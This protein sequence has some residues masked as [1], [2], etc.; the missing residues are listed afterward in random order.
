LTT[1]QDVLYGALRQI[2]SVTPGEPIDGTEASN[3]LTVI[4]RLLAAFSMEWG[5]IQDVTVENFPL[6]VGQ[7]SYTW[8]IGGNFNSVRPDKIFNC[9]IYDSQAGIR[10]PL[11]VLSDNQYQGIMLNTISSIPKAIYYDQQYPLGIVYIYPTASLTTYSLYTETYKPIAQFAT[12]TST[13]NLPGEYFEELVML[14]ADELAPEYGY[15]MTQRQI[16]KVDY[17]KDLMKARNFKRS[18]AEFDSAINGSAHLA[19]G[20]ILDGFIS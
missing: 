12:L 10:Y 19:G 8:G 13:M 2:S 9:W 5:L 17:V 7:V 1:C 15:E 4:N 14:T 16:Q 20:T 11:K 3:A 18:V 6:V